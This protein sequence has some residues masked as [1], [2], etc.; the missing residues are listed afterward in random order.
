LALVF[1]YLG[2][3]GIAFLSA[4][5]HNPVLWYT[6][7]VL[8]AFAM[9]LFTYWLLGR[10]EHT[11]RGAHAA[12]SSRWRLPK[13]T[14]NF[15]VEHVGISALVLFVFWLPAIIVSFPCALNLDTI[16]SFYQFENTPPV[17]Y[18]GIYY[19]VKFVDH[20]PVFDTLIFG[21]FFAA[22]DAM[23]NQG[24][25]LFLLV[26]CQAV[27]LALVLAAACCYLERLGAPSWFS[28]ATLAFFALFPAFGRYA[29]TL[30]KDPMFL[31]PWVPFFICY[32]EVFR[33]DGEA[34][35]KKS[36]LIVLVLSA[37]FCILT[38]KLGP[39]IVLPSLFILILAVK[40]NRLESIGS[41]VAVVLV[42]QLLF[43]AIVYP[44]IGGVQPG[45]IQEALGFTFQQVITVK[46]E[47]PQ[48]ITDE[49]LACVDKV[50]DTEKAL[51]NYD[52][53]ITDPV[54]G[55]YRFDSTKEE[56]LD[57]LQ[58]WAA[59]G[60]RHPIIYLGTLAQETCGLY[61]PSKVMNYYSIP[62]ARNKIDSDYHGK[63]ANSLE[64][65][66]PEFKIKMH[67]PEKLLQ[68]DSV[69]NQAYEAVTHLPII[70]IVF[71]CGFY[72][73][74]IPFLAFLVTFYRR[75][76][77]CLALVPIVLSCLFLVLSPTSSARYVLPLV[78]AA[79]LIIAWAHV[80]LQSPDREQSVEPSDRRPGQTARGVAR[81]RG[82]AEA[83]QHM[84]SSDRDFGQ[85]TRSF[86]WEWGLAGS[87]QRIASSDQIS[88][89]MPRGVAWGRN[90]RTASK[91]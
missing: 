6:L 35:K 82:T 19:P 50:L 79:P 44:A 89:Q 24:M 33:T 55:Y 4:L 66:S 51:Q 46:R 11:S 27:A 54:K 61:V 22:G 47:N 80:K 76:R 16:D 23:G 74:W 45:G 59:V 90:N 53:I 14:M 41:L 56:L 40:R 57:Y 3:D 28:L 81:A 83:T 29:A 38:K 36:V 48:G 86:A 78:A 42:F 62:L 72:G 63:H 85:M 37:G 69:L 67:R 65:I 77:D 25:A 64:R 71:T 13:L 30:L 12:R 10:D 31:V 5:P 70:S 20:H 21:S 18:M 8:I 43:P 15:D 49:E 68:I 9:G 88:G 73:G 60:L 34:L 87:E 17:F 39:Y 91:I 2:Y 52:P 32:L 58:T 26:I 75:K 1:A 7:I 84:A